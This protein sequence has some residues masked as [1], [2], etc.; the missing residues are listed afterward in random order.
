MNTLRKIRIVY[1]DPDA[2]D[3]SSEEDTRLLSHGYE[4][5]GC[6]KRVVKEMF[7]C[8]PSKLH[9]ENSS[10]GNINS[11]KIKAC[12]GSFASRRN[13]KSSSV[14]RGGV[15]IWLGTFDTEEEAGMA[16]E[17]KKIEFES[18][19]LALS[20]K[21]ALASSDSAQ[22]VLF[23]PSPSSV[24]DVSTTKAPLDVRDGSVKEKVIVE[25][26]EGGNDVEP[27]Y[28]EDD[29]IQYLLD[30]PVVPSLVGHDLYLNEVEKGPMLLGNEFC[31]F[32]DNDIEDGSMWNVKHEEGSIL[33][34]VDSAFDELA[35]I[36]ET[37]NW[38][39]Y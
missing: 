18:S 20:K 13:R 9:T 36:D 17:R 34:P 32:L 39:C 16:C 23:H 29:S 10:Q 37:L 3:Y 4:L 19:L 28:S 11:E 2:T 12:S 26:N 33:S 35:W 7:P 31:N 25:A 22:E 24:L 21:G 5:N 15:R 27:D 1:T 6:S 8:M 14:Y 30:E 38:E